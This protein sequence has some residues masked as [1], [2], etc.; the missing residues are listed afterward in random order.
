MRSLV[1]QALHGH[2]PP[3]AHVVCICQVEC[4]C[5][6]D[7]E[8]DLLKKTTPSGHV[9]VLFSLIGCI[10]SVTTFCDRFT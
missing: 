5:A 9:V 2:D 10:G 4:I 7:Q 8:E 6:L 1:H 3:D